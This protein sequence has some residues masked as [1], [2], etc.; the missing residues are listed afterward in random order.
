MREIFSFASVAFIIICFYIVSVSFFIYLLS[1]ISFLGIRIL[2]WKSIVFFSLGTF[3]WMI[4]YE[5]I[6]LLHS[7]RVRNK[8]IL[9]L[10]VALLN[11]IL[12]SYFIYLFF[13]IFF[14]F[15]FL[16]VCFSVRPHPP[17]PPP[18]THPPTPPPPPPPP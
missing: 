16:F 13:F 14:F 6:S 11:V 17:T 10:L 9:N 2:E 5:V 3:F 8:A 7:I 1:L 12:F 4:P 15:F 18:P